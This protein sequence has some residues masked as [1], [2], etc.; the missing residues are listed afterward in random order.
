MS[1]NVYWV[2]KVRKVSTKFPPID[3]KKK[4]ITIYDLCV[5]QNLTWN[6]YYFRA[7]PTFQDLQ[8][9]F[10]SLKGSANDNSRQHFGFQNRE[11]YSVYIAIKASTTIWVKIIWMRHSEYRSREL[12]KC[13]HKFLFQIVTEKTNSMK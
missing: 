10:R 8:K 13:H 11:V 3:N 6:A 4:R 5:M 1:L 9:T 12:D 2:G 7:L